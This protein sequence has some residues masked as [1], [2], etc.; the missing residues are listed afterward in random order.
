MTVMG[1]AAWTNEEIQFLND[2]WR[3]M[4]DEQLAKH[5]GRTKSSVLG[6]RNLLG[7]LGKD[8]A[9]RKKSWSEDELAR[10]EEMW[11]T[12]TIPQIAKRLGRSNHAVKV[13]GA[14]LHLGRFVDSSE[15]MTANQ[16]S[17]LLGVDIHAVTN[18]WIP[19]KGLKC[20]KKAPSGS[21]VMK[22]IQIGHLIQW[23]KEHQDLWDSRKL[24]RYA[25]GC[26]PQWLIDKRSADMNK[27]KR[28]AQKWTPEEDAR[29]IQLYK[30]GGLKYHQIGEILGRSGASVERR[31]LRLDVWGSGEYIGH[32][33]AAMRD[34]VRERYEKLSLIVRLVQ[35]LNMRKNQLN[36]D[37]FWQKG[38]CMN[39]D[40][41]SGCKAGEQNCDECISF[42]RIK[43]QFCVRCGAT[44]LERKSNLLCERCRVARKKQ[45]QRAW[46]AKSSAA[47]RRSS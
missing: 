43:P 45:Y 26:E 10:L 17:V 41:I 2:N 31:L 47:I 7:L 18:F 46:A 23:L 35:L 32:K 4:T 24:D 27:P 16:V 11:G 3:A 5:L 33:K 40:D 28:H 42:I 30:A 20:T 1:K 34:E 6:K 21:R 14:R 38:M 39:W 19:K 25:L 13:K 29:C 44:F 15:Y 22:H 8:I 37:G 12:Y 36:Y 9:N